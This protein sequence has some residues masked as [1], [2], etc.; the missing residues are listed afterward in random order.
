MH[1]LN[2]PLVILAGILLFSYADSA[3]VF[4]AALFL[5]STLGHSTVHAVDPTVPARLYQ[6][7][8][9]TLTIP[10]AKI[11]RQRIDHR[12]SIEHPTYHR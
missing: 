11:L 2:P 6:I 9:L 1:H 3:R 10:H 5:H 4:S 8:L 7:C 12:T